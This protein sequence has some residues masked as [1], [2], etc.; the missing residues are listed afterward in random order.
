MYCAKTLILELRDL[1][2]LHYRKTVEFFSE[3]LITPGTSSAAATK[4]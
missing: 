1:V 4:Y 3:T 2:I